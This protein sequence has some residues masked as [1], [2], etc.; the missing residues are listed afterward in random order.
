MHPN[1]MA[2][3]FILLAGA[4][5]MTWPFVL[6]RLTEF[7]S[8]ARWSPL[9]VVVLFAIPICYLLAESL[10]RL[11]AATVYATFVG[12]GTAGTAIIG[13]LFFGESTGLGRVCS[14]LLLLAGLVGLRIFSGAPE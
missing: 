4:F 12:I 6:K 11:P 7:P 3:L 14:L 8:A 2:W 9:L 10:K 1:T 5:E 13:I